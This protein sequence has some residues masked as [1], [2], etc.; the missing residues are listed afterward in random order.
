[1]QDSWQ[2]K[3]Q[4]YALAASPLVGLYVNLA[5]QYGRFSYLQ[6][7]LPL[8]DVTKFDLF[9]AVVTG[10]Y[11]WLCVALWPILLFVPWMK[12]KPAIFAHIVVNTSLVTIF[13]T[14]LNPQ[15]GASAF[16]VFITYA[17]IGAATMISYIASI[18]LEEEPSL[19]NDPHVP[20]RIIPVVYLNIGVFV[21]LFFGL[22][23]FCIGYFAEKKTKVRVVSPSFAN[24]IVVD[25]GPS[26]LILKPFNEKDSTFSPGTAR[27]VAPPPDLLLDQKNIQLKQR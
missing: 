15:F 9:S 5:Q 2:S 12:R 3:Y 18:M 1:M 8:I 21:L 14:G 23:S 11:L 20:T 7:P 24:H 4:A 25:V 19:K 22:F 26:R 27:V 16:S 10:F 13:V 17:L 6:I